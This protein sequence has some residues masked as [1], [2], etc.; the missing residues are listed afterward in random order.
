MGSQPRLGSK[1]QTLASLSGRLASAS[2]LPLVSFT[3]AR[4]Q[5]GSGPIVDEILAQPWAGDGVI[6]RSSASLEDTS[7]ASLAGHF[8]SV[9]GV[10]GAPALD[11][12]DAYEQRSIDRALVELDGTDDR[13]GLGAN[14]MLFF[15]P[16]LH[17]LFGGELPGAS[18]IL[19][20]EDG[21]EQL[22]E[23]LEDLSEETGWDA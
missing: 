19:A 1:A 16:V 22:I 14:A 11:G 9:L 2:V 3:V 5:E 10:Q 17:G 13:S 7:T 23:R 6:V 15:D 4:W 18:A 20:D 8:S 21:I 12:M